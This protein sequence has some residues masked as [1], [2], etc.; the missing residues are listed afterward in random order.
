MKLRIRGNS[1]RFRLSQKELEQLAEA[2]SA[3]DSIR[4]A[5][6]VALTYRVS[7]SSGP[8]RASFDGAL[9][10]VTLSPAALE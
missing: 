7:V 1:V 6:G 2:G 9:V 3:E 8:V 10:A 5:P 4:F